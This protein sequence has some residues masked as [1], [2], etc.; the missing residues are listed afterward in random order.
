MNAAGLVVP[1]DEEA[2]RTVA[3]CVAATV[4]G[5]L[6]AHQRLRASDFH[7]PACRRVFEAAEIVGW[8]LSLAERVARIA[9]TAKVDE[10]AVWAMVRKRPVM[11]DT[12]G[13]YAQRV[14]D[15]SRRRQVMIVAADVYNALGQ[16]GTLAD[17]VAAL[18]SL[19][20]AV[21]GSHQ[22]SKPRL[23]PA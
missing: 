1:M 22:V 11:D 14:R 3:G 21:R 23:V 7:I 15:A 16:G 2:E 18:E 9:D 13:C 8:A 20:G 4:H 19:L 5:S 12:S 10:V 6:L 17:A